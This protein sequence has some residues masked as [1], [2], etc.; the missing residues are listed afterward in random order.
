[1]D[2]FQFHSGSIQTSISLRSEMLF[3]P[4]SIPLWFDSNQL[5]QALVRFYQLVS[6]PLWFDSN[7]VSRPA[8]P[9]PG[10]VSI[11]LW[12]DSNLCISFPFPEERSRFNSTLVRFKLITQIRQGDVLLI[13]SIP[14]W[15]D[16]NSCSIEK[17]REIT[18][19]QF[20]SGSIQTRGEM[21][22]NDAYQKSFN[23]TLVRFKRE[24]ECKRRLPLAVS[25]PLWFD[26]NGNDEQG[27][28]GAPIQ[29]SIPLWFDSN[30]NS[31]TRC[32]SSKRFQFHSGSIQ[33][34]YSCAGG[35]GAVWF[36]FH[37][38]SIQTAAQEMNILKL[39][40]FQFHS[41]SIQT[42]W[43]AFA[44]TGAIYSF[45]STLVRFKPL[46]FEGFVPDQVVSIPLWFDSNER[47]SG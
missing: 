13:V 17:Q 8:G 10:S 28:Q 1:M 39:H 36:Q 21:F 18:A 33:T 11:P 14:L 30:R 3:I 25:I 43:I 22:L 2:R 12:F 9:R 45:N 29:V 42:R 35:L 24:R 4:V 16:S 5:D 26:S 46:S 23:S 41:G 38:G 40:M 31:S 34:C 6:I 44:G 7:L 20:H 15:F 47:C 27:D 37:S 19:F 32:N